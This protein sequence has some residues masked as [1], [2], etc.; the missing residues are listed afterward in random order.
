MHPNDL[1]RLALAAEA[2]SFDLSPGPLSL[3]P[4]GDGGVIAYYHGAY[5]AAGSCCPG[6]LNAPVSVNAAQFATVASLYTGTDKPVSLKVT[7][8]AL[9]VSQGRRR[10]LLNGQGRPDVSPYLQVRVGGSFPFSVDA[11]LLR[12]EVAMAAQCAASSMSIPVLRGVRVVAHG[13]RLG[14]MSADGSSLVYKSEVKVASASS[15]LSGVIPALDL[16]SSMRV[17]SGAEVEVRLSTVLQLYDGNGS[18]V[19]LPMLS[20]D[21]PKGFSVLTEF[22]PDEDVEIPAESLRTVVKAMTVYA[23]EDLAEVVIR[24]AANGVGAVVESK[25]T[26]YGRF[27]EGFEYVGSI[28]PISKPYTLAVKDLAMMAKLDPGAP[29]RIQFGGNLALCEVPN[30]AHGTRRRL[31]ARQRTW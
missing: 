22:G 4:D 18:Y 19:R 26:E 25:G 24:P 8:A 12:A 30:D 11:A 14:F 29:V 31:Y 6:E 15:F 28:A 2:A 23:A 9:T 3:C 27:Q 17:L 5:I 13:D 7:G 10:S 21:W 20:G 1:K 16:A